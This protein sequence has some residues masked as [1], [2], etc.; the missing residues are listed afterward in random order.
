MDQVTLR[1]W[2]NS[3]G[4]R[5][6]KDIIVKMQLQNDDVM[7]ICIENDAIVLRKQ[8]RHKSFEERLA[9]YDGKISVCDFD[10][11]EPVGREIL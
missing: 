6:P 7:D 1:A 8:F 3:Q 11:G 5:I 9:E 2:G 10:W 4:I